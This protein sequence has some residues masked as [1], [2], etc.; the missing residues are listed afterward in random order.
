M[1]Y[2]RQSDNGRLN[3]WE[4][5]QCGRERN[6]ARTVEL[7]VCPASTDSRLDNFHL[8][9]NGGRICWLVD[10]TLC[11]VSVR[12]NSCAGKVEK[13]RRCLKCGFYNHVKTQ[14]KGGLVR[15]SEV[16]GVLTRR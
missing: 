5:I 14:E 7:G 1:E 12:G 15:T 3:C 9:V 2:C 8:G 11:D 10:G 16:F 13:I 4:F 6:G